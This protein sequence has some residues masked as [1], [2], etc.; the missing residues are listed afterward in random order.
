M[1]ARIVNSRDPVL[2]ILHAS[3]VYSSPQN[4]ESQ[5]QSFGLREKENCSLSLHLSTGGRLLSRRR[6]AVDIPSVLRPRHTRN[7]SFQQHQG[8]GTNEV[9]EQYASMHQGG[10]ERTGRSRTRVHRE[11]EIPLVVDMVGMRRCR[12]NGGVFGVS[13]GSVC[14]LRRT[15]MT[16]STH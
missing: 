9:Y 4:T 5:W 3:T 6:L 8:P 15:N 16:C 1:H 14:T 2:K 10:P 11:V 7:P 12:G 13:S